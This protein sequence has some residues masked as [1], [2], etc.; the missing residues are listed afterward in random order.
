[1]IIGEAREQVIENIR[2]AVGEGAFHAKVEVGDPLL[3]EKQKE[4]LLENYLKKR[5]SYGF[6]I[7]SWA[8]RHAAGFV[9]RMINRST[10][11]MGLENIGDIAGGAIVTSNHFS[12]LDNTVVRDLVWRLGKKKLC[13]VSQESNLAMSG[14]IGYLTN[15]ADTIPI[16]SVP[17]YMAGEFEPLLKGALDK[18]EYVLIYPEQEMW[19]NYCKP[20]PMKRGAYYYAAKF[21]VPVISCFLE[22]HVLDELDTSEFYKVEYVM[23]VL[24]TIYPDPAKPA[25]G[26]SVIMCK[27]DYEQKKDA[28]ESVYGRPLDYKFD[29][30]DIAGWIPTQIT[31]DKLSIDFERFM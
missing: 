8:A 20:R 15:Y 31:P 17:G 12:P 21:K 26:N 3:T 22:M 18:K 19:F 28:Y 13:I 9:T 14:F 30:A 5:K 2:K 10:K 1:M 25:R 24:P 29:P 7:N 16:S 27:K 6:R 11:I 23:H 4:N